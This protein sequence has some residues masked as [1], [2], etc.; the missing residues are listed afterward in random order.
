[1][2]ATATSVLKLLQ[3]SKVFLIPTFQRRYTW[4][5]EQWSQLWDD[6]LNEYYVVHPEDPD[7]LHG[8]FLGSVVLHPALGPAS[9]LMR[10]QVVDGQQRLTTIMILLAALRDVR[11]QHDPNW[12]AK[13]INE[14]YLQNA[15]SPD[16][17][18][19]LVPTRLDRE[20]FAK[21]VISSIPTGDIGIAYNF[22][23]AAIEKAIEEEDISLVNLQNTLL[24]HMLVV[25]INTKG[26]DSV[27][28]I[29]NTLNSKGLALSP[30]D[31]VRNEILHYFPED[32]AEEKHGSL[33]IPMEEALVKPKAKQ[34][35]REFVTFLWAREVAHD[36]K[37]SR[38]NLFA[39]FERRFRNTV[40]E[41][42]L[43]PTEVAS[44]QLQEM[45]DDHQLF[46]IIRNPSLATEYSGISGALAN[47]LQLLSS[48]KSEPTTPIALWILKQ[49][50]YGRVDK[51]DAAAAL[52]LLLSY[53]VK[54]TLNGIPT[55]QLNRLLTPVANELSKGLDKND[56]VYNTLRSLLS[57]QGYYWPTDDQVLNNVASNP[58]YASS[59]RYVRFLL[60]TAENSMHG[61]ETANTGNT[62]VEH[63]MPQNLSVG[64]E[65]YLSDRNV[66]IE[67]AESVVHTLGNLTLTDNNQSMGNREFVSKQR[68]YFED[69]ALRLNRALADLPDFTPAEIAK[70]SVELATYILQVFNEKPL[71]KSDS[72]LEENSQL[73]VVERLQTILQTLPVDRFVRE[74]DLISVLGADK[75]GVKEAIRELD[76]TLARLIRDPEGNIPDWLGENL[77]AGI[78]AQ[79]Q[80]AGALGKPLSEKELTELTEAANSGIDDDSEENFEHADD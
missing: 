2:K 53:L 23:K 78:T 77:I 47:S 66:T 55:N 10:H 3:G 9:T 34:P 42:S 4:K 28:S 26:G 36:P 25:E 80:A 58:I 38:E 73:T 27:H 8:H 7:S 41:S 20:A 79:D 69:S 5:K 50:V 60:E 45:Y 1:M 52:H 46:L 70:R 75:N 49:A 61:F 56:S 62:Q 33:W 43:K 21:T 67:D 51:D 19:R 31:L 15:F 22:F 68:E 39:T 24:L 65:N 63:I 18:E 48:W 29:F 37:T 11:S 14:Q 40:S 64:W 74:V 72:S 13:E 35:D 30:A 16:Y 59:R 76:P 44:I 54:R 71:S 6:L 12:N 57:R 32:V 17:P